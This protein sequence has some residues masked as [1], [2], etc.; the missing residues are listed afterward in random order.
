MPLDI[1]TLFDLATNS[2]NIFQSATEKKQKDLDHTDHEFYYALSQSSQ[3]SKSGLG[4]DQAKFQIYVRKLLMISICPIT[5][6][7]RCP[8]LESPLL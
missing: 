8:N 2:S 6:I 3:Q 4:H 1:C 7:L 5:L